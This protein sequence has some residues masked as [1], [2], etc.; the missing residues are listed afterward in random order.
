MRGVDVEVEQ[1]GG[2]QAECGGRGRLAHAAGTGAACCCDVWAAARQ[3]HAGVV[4]RRRGCEQRGRGE[5]RAVVGVDVCDGCGVELREHGLQR[6]GARGA[7][8][9]VA[10]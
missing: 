5:Q 2:V 3:P 9:C 4:L 7:R 8:G 1:R 6:P 10:C